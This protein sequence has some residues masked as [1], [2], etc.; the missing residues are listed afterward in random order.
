MEWAERI[1]TMT[2]GYRDSCILI[3]ALKVGIFEALGEDKR[4][5]KELAAA[6]DL[7]THA[8]D[9]V[10]CALAAVEI[11]RKEDDRFTIDPGARPYLLPGG[12]ETMVSIIGHNRSMLRSWVQL[13]D[14]MRTGTPA[15]RQER[16][17]DEM[18]DFI[19][20]MENVSR[21]SSEEVASKIDFSDARRLLDLG[22]G[23]GT[24]AITFARANPELKCVVFDLEGPVGIAAEQIKKAAFTDRV[25]TRAGDFL[26]DDIGRDFDVVYISN[27]IH[28]LSPT[29]TLALLEKA[30]GALVAGGRVLVKDFFLADSRIEP[31]WTAQFSVNMLVNT[32]GGK[33][34]T[35]TEMKDLM[36]RAG[37]G[38]LKTVGIARNSMVIVG[39]RES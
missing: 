25:T 31:P 12:P 21:R 35:F 39:R 16:S 24:A 2:A 14:V 32:E 18:E 4:T 22:G 26:T 10:M 19:R 7:D 23:P 5:S 36:A 37:F 38:G 9:V 28:M 11:L 6:L 30:S 34:Y 15:T 3:A 27:I 8:V 29:K 1:E 17:T 13:E 20:G 33:S